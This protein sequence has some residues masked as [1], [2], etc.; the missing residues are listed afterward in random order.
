MRIAITA[1]KLKN[2]KWETLATPDIHVSTQKAAFKALKLSNGQGGKYEVAIIL[3]SSGQIKR[4]QFKPVKAE[5]K[6]A[7][8][9]KAE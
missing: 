8:A 9:K 7:A 6:K 4:A 3:T 5:P 1:A 2:G